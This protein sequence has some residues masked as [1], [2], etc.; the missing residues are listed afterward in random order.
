MALFP[1]FAQ[2]KNKHVLVVGGGAIAERKIRLLLKT[3]ALLTVRALEFNEGVRQLAEHPQV[4]L[5]Q[6]AFT[7]DL[8]DAVQLVIAA[9]DNAD[10]NA[11]IA[12][13][14]NDRAIFVN[15]V[16]DPELSTIQVPAI[17]DR[18][19]LMIGVSS[20]GAAP[21]IARAVRELVESVLD[22]GLGH[23]AELVQEY[24]PQIK[25]RW[26]NLA[27]RRA[28]YSKLMSGPIVAL[29]REQQ[30]EQARLLLEQ[31]LVQDEQKSLKGAV[32][33][34]PV[35]DSD[36]GQLTLNILRALNQADWIV[37][38]PGVDES[39]LELARR[40]A[41]RF[42]WP[43]T[44]PSVSMHVSLIEEH[45][46]HPALQGETVVVLM[47]GACPSIDDIIDCCSLHGIYHRIYKAATHSDMS[48]V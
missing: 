43:A 42:S 33:M 34:V 31:S 13:A 30:W 20:S 29:L 25:Q 24:R 27:Q 10:V 9:T 40:D 44:V 47:A 11:L 8:L 37:H 15:V 28:F 22:E 5:S 19:P 1:F 35:E 45:I 7:L 46:V 41:D 26:P 4:E 14:A 39:I 48:C 12:G 6:G 21:M 3:Q 18:R 23:L 36:R 16:D 32:I 2:L 17:I 38:S